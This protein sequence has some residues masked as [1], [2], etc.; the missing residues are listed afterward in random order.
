MRWRRGARRPGRR[1]SGKNRCGRA[2]WRRRARRWIPRRRASRGGGESVCSFGDG[3]LRRRRREGRG[4]VRGSDGAPH[5]EKQVESLPSVVAGISA[6]ALAKGGFRVPQEIPAHS[7]IR[8][9][10]GAPSN[11][12]GIGR[13]DTGTGWTGATGSSKNCSRRRT[14]GGRGNSPTGNTRRACGSSERAGERLRRERSRRTRRAAA[15][16]ANRCDLRA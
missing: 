11:R 7:W 9:G 15:R 16:D 13:G 6:E 3:R 1:E 4:E 8:R 12:F 5:E 2:G 10:A 14:I